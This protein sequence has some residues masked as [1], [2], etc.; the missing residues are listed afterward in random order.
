[1]N[2]SYD[3]NTAVVVLPPVAAG[4]L[5]DRSLRSWLAQSDLE[6]LQP[7]VDWSTEILAAIG[8]LLPASG[9]GAL[10]M[11]GQ[12]GDRPNAWVAAADPVYLEAQLDHLRLHALSETDVSRGEL[13]Q[14]FDYL[15]VTLGENSG[16]GFACI[17]GCGYVTAQAPFAT[18]QFPA[19]TV[20]DCVPNDFLPAGEAAA[21]HRGLLSEV[22]MALHEHPVN[23]ER[24]SAGRPP[25]NSLWLWGGGLAPERQTDPHPPLF[26]DDPLLAGYWESNTGLAEP[27]PG[28]IQGCLEGAVNGFVATLPGDAADAAVL[29]VC[30]G[31]LRSALRSNRLQ[32]LVLLFRDGI[33]AEVRRAHALR[34]WRRRSDLLEAVSEQ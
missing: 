26:S 25:V 21:S 7:P 33:R 9:R 18:A 34:V 30:L 4:R 1:M 14:L 13:G 31:E 5:Q 20:D 11:W 8:K 32:R 16:Y 27:W 23:L 22:E 29:D 12:T 3:K 15:Q 19:T 2:P 24:Q 28:T 10:R 17:G 6:Q